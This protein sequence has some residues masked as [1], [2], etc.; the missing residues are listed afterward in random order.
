MLNFVYLRSSRLHF[1][2]F[3]FSHALLTRGEVWACF[4]L[5]NASIS[6]S[7]GFESF[8]G[9]VVHR[10]YDHAK[11]TTKYTDYV[12]QDGTIVKSSCTVHVFDGPITR[13]RAKKLHE[14]V[15]TL[16]CEIPFIDENYILPKSCIFLL[17]TFIKEEDKDTPRMNHIEDPRRISSAS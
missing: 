1:C 2:I 9:S 15:H 17:L 14:E 10:W 12:K 8:L 7:G 6:F 4:G 5:L 3:S 16:L 13:S 11:H